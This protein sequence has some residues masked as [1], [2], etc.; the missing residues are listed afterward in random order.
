MAEHPQPLAPKILTLAYGVFY[1]SIMLTS[2]YSSFYSIEKITS[3]ELYTIPI[4]IGIFLF[5]VIMMFFQE[6]IAGV[7]FLCWHFVIWFMVLGFWD[8]GGINII[9]AFP[10]LILAIWLIYNW[11]FYNHPQQN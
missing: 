6:L 11:Y 5:G 4:A 2:E 1:L 3:I 7:V 9:L 8:L 10:I